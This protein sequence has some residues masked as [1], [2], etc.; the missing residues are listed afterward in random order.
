MREFDE[1]ETIGAGRIVLA[2]RGGRGVVREG[3]HDIPPKLTWPEK[4]ISPHHSAEPV[5][6]AC[7]QT[8]ENDVVM[9]ETCM[10]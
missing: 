9:R 8:L 2:D 4:A 5:H 10:M 3:T 1:L 6:G 7:I